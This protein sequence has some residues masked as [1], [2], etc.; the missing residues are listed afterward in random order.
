MLDGGVVAREPVLDAIGIQYAYD[1]RLTEGFYVAIA[2][3]FAVRWARDGLLR[4]YKDYRGAQE[5]P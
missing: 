5:H 2:F 3:F 4:A 1:L